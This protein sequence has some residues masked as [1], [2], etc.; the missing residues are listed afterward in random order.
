MILLH[1]L[2]GGLYMQ[3]SWRMNMI[4]ILLHMQNWATCKMNYCAQ[5]AWLLIPVFIITND[6][7]G[8]MSRPVLLKDVAWYRE[9][10]VELNE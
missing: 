4:F 6:T 10:L 8:S 2:K 7:S 9:D 3:K 1:L 5:H